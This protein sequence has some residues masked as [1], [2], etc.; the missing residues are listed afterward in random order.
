LRQLVIAFLLA[1]CG[2]TASVDSRTRVYVGAYG[3]QIH[4]FTLDPA[5]L[6]M[7]P[8]GAV[9]AGLFPSFL[10]MDP[11]SRWLVASL[12]GGSAVASFAIDDDGVLSAIGEEPVGDQPAHVT[13]DGTGAWVMA[14]NFGGGSVSVLS[15]D[16]AGALGPAVEVAAD[17]TVHQVAMH[18]NNAVAF[19]PCLD[20]NGIVTFSFDSSTGAL[21]P[22]SNVAALPG[23]GPRHVAI[24]RTGN[25]AWVMN[26]FA[27]SVTAFQ[28]ARDGV[29]REQ[30]TVSALPSGFTGDNTGAE[31]ALHPTLDV[32]YTSNRGHDSIAVFDVMADGSL[33]LR[34]TVGTGA[35]P[36]HFSIVPD[37]TGML[38]ANQEAGSIS[39]FRIDANGDLTEV[40][41]VAQVDQPGFVGVIELPA[42]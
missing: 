17:D 37:G 14:S 24:S 15:I 40:G 4:A 36:R 13:L 11:E 22:T 25:S 38:V 2:E 30:D 28:I 5:T 33:A 12:E 26:E 21:A 41:E 32:L 23:G 18:P 19:A 3:L 9:D 8:I 35:V 31:I 42:R 34:T 20:A 10:A 29:L 16:G 6:A 1:A 39:A 27:S 7:T